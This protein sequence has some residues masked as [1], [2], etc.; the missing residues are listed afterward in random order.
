MFLPQAAIFDMDGTLLDSMWVWRQI[1][2]DFLAAHGHLITPDYTDAIKCMGWEEGAR[3]T[4]DRY[5]LDQTPQQVIE[6]W[7]DMCADYYRT[8]IDL[9]PYAREYLS[10]LHE[11]GIPMAIAT[12][13]EP[14]HNIDIVL[15]RFDMRSF[16]QN[17]TVSTEVSRG[18]GFP[19]I[20]AIRGAKAG[21][22]Q[23][24]GIY[25]TVSEGD[26]EDIKNEADVAVRSWKDLME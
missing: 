1:D 19:D 15:D 21:A 2:A 16:F 8:R 13:M 10:F 20:G 18:K 3:Y 11:H 17:I 12:S 4:I 23:T 5:G 7:F 6:E 22:F 14:Q 25:D 24:V 9:K 26:W